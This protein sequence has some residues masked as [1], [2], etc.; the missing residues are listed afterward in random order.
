[1]NGLYMIVNSVADDPFAIDVAHYFGQAAEIADL[2][3]LKR[4][5]NSELCPRFISDENDL[6]NIGRRLQGRTV[7][8]VSTCCG[9]HTR[10]ALAMRTCLVARAAKDN[11]AA[12]VLLVEPD[13]FYS[14]QDR[15]PAANQGRVDFART[16][17]DCK[18]FDGQPW[19]ARLYAELLHTSG[20][21]GVVTV[22]NHSVSVQRLFAEVFGGQF[23]NLS[24]AELYANYLIT[25]RIDGI[26]GKAQGAVL[27]APDAG[28][29]SFVLNVQTELERACSDLLLS[30]QVDIL[31]M[32]KE[33]SGERRVEVRAAP[34]SPLDLPGVSGREVIVFDDMVRTGNTIVECCRALK[35]AG[36]RRVV[37]VVTHF[38]SSDEVKEN[39]NTPV[40]DEIV[41]SNTL[42]TILNRDSQGRLRKK[43]LVLKIERWIADFL[44]Q[45]CGLR[46]L[47]QGGPLYT[48]DM[49]AKNPRSSDIRAS[50]PQ[51]RTQT[52]RESGSEQ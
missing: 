47:S 29:R 39:L 26:I 19:S 37:F 5:A 7:V 24:P 25:D 1:M 6:A 36:A 16:P 32:C 45:L 21:D 27:C 13:L 46:G 9:N 22:H 14:A 31:T 38:Y 8:I 48:I 49:S 28:A 18:K 3:S 42:P 34:E 50:L 2:I 41:T 52:K 33:R 20:V 4:F 35:N 23:Y 43:M 51:A 11:G 15:G 10:N 17:Q 40:I 12:R 44:R 30:P